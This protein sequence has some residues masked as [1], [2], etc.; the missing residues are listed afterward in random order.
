MT[1]PYSSYSGDLTVITQA[2]F[3]KID[4]NKSTFRIPVQG[5]YYGDQD[6]LPV[7]PAVCLEPGTK[8]RT[9]VGQPNMTQNDFEVFIL[10]YHDMI[11]STALSR[12]Q[13]DQIAYDI[14]KLIHQ[15]LQLTNGGA[16]NLIHGFVAAHESGYTYKVRTLYRAARL[17]YRGHNKT[18]LPFA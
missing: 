1:A 4:D 2:L 13:A 17:T 9:L 12:L 15:D 18:S 14:E 3:T 5:V 7:T 16:P 11:Q 6:R 8:Q 10:V